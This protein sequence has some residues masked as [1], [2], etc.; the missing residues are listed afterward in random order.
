MADN[1]ISFKHR[2]C[3]DAIF[4]PWMLIHDWANIN[5]IKKRYE[6]HGNVIIE[7]PDG[8]YR[9]LKYE[10]IPNSDVME[11]VVIYLLKEDEG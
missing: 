4:Q 2:Q 3:K 5:R 11:T 7:F 1:I 8:D 6:G 9:Y 10:I